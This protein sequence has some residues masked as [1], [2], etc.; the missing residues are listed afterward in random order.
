[1]III[2]FLVYVYFDIFIFIFL[3]VLFFFMGK[4]VYFFK[5]DNVN[6]DIKRLVFVFFIYL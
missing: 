1:M 4:E 3:L 2:L 5:M 6:V